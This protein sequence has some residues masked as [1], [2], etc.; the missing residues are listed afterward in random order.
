MRQAEA[1]LNSVGFLD[2]AVSKKGTYKVGRFLNRLL[3]IAPEIQNRFI[4]CE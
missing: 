1:A 2:D 3:G 4:I